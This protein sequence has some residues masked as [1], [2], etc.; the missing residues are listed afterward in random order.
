MV[1]RTDGI[2]GS[3]WWKIDFHVHTPA[4]GDYRRRDA[5]EEDVLQAAMAAGL[6]CMVIADHNS[7][8]WIDRLKE[9]NNEINV[10][11]PKPDWYRELVIFP[12]V[13]I[14]AANS[15]NRVHLIAIFDPN[16]DTRKIISVLGACGIT[17]GFGDAQNTV[18]K[19]SFIETIEAIENAGGIAIPAHIDGT[20]GLLHNATALNVELSNSLKK[21]HAAEFCDPHKFDNA[22]I[23]LQEAI[24]KIAKVGGSDGH[25]PEEIG[26]HHGWIKMGFPSLAGLRLALTDNE[27]CVK[28]QEED[29]NYLPDV[30]FDQL[31]IRNMKYCG[32][33]P[34]QPLALPLNPGFNALIGGRGSGKSTLLESIRIAARRDRNLNVEAPKIKEK[35][36]K[37]LSPKDGALLPDTEIILDLWRNGKQFRL[38]WHNSQEGNVLEEKDANGDWQFTEQGN[39]QERFPVSIFSQKQIEELASNPRALLEFIDHSPSV[40]RSEW[41]SR[42]ENNKSQFLQLRERWRDLHRRLAE[43]PQIRVKLTDLEND[44]KQYEEKGH[45]N[46][47]KAYQ[48][49]SL[50]KNAL[51][52]DG[53]FDDSVAKIRELA[54]AIGLTDFPDHLFDDRGEADIELKNIYEQTGDKLKTVAATLEGAAQRIKQIKD[55]LARSVAESKWNRSVIANGA[56]YQQLTE[57]YAQKGSKLDLALYGEWTQQ[58]HQCAEQL[59]NMDA[60]KEEIVDVEN[61]ID[62]CLSRC[63]SLRAELLEKRRNFLDH[64]IGSNAFVRMEIVAFG[65][66]NSLESYYRGLFNLEGDRFASSILDAPGKQ[67]LL[68]ELSAWQE[69][70]VPEDKLPDLV[71]AVKKNTFAVANGQTVNTGSPD[72]RLKT[73]L[74]GILENQPAVLDQLDIWFPEDLLRVKYS[75]D[76]ASGK[77]DDISNGSAGQKAAAILAFL[78]SYGDQPLLIDQPEDDLDNALIYDL[79]VSQIH[80]NKSRRQLIIATHNPNIVVNGDAELVVSLKFVN[81]QVR[82]DTCGGLEGPDVRESVCTI[83][84]GGREAFEKR[85]KRITLEA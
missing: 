59:R 1:K 33:I 54:S 39:L 2:P 7:G 23:E 35:L 71:S 82:I 73:R 10:R 76:T 34:D 61:Q 32:R 30:W 85:Y 74:Q 28:N 11:N 48:R 51:P 3:K 58:R 43:E 70:N 25:C 84:E 53:A 13:E 44:L 27:Y 75:R 22:D 4:S 52:A 77:F 14:T 60:I 31:Q 80:A 56:A 72:N 12:G 24:K 36:D 15:A 49:Y 50:Q 29:P 37:F 42:R 5:T 79:I 69:N 81:G 83:M 6:D 8:D 20:N 64:V 38:R 65:D 67:G 17:N 63:L 66:V 46:I 16:C 47:L 78:L 19:T 26:R 45:G 18:T 57:E 68:W 9:K 40:N 41:D 21:I 62:A 55:E